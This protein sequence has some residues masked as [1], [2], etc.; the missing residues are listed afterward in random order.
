MLGSR[1]VRAKPTALTAVA[2]MIGGFFIVDDPFSQGLAVSPIFGILIATVL[3]LLII[4]IACFG[5]MNRILR[6]S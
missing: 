1:G 6:A 3:T 2:A 4:P 5:W